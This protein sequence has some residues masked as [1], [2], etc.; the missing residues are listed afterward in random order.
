VLSR[1]A[2]N[3]EQSAVTETGHKR[4]LQKAN[5]PGASIASFR[6][7]LQRERLFLSGTQG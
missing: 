3:R 1:E 5:K 7:Q 2:F 4:A 6:G